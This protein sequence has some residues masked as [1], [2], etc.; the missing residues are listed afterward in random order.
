MCSGVDA[1]SDLARVPRRPRTRGHPV[2]RQQTCAKDTLLEVQGDGGR[3]HLMADLCAGVEQHV[4][5]FFGPRAPPWSRI[6][7]T[8]SWGPFR[9]C[10]TGQERAVRVRTTLAA[11]ALPRRDGSAMSGESGPGYRNDATQDDARRGGRADGGGNGRRGAAGRTAASR[12]ADPVGPHGAA[13]WHRPGRAHPRPIR[14]ALRREPGSGRPARPLGAAG[15][16]AAAAH[17]DGLGRRGRREALGDRRLCRAARQQQ[18]QPR[19]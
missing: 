17:R 4:G 8:S 3:Q 19:L 7:R 2:Q 13:A 9:R 18:L 5:Y 12:A 1:T 11:Q 6:G 14:A 15:A 16:A 10:R